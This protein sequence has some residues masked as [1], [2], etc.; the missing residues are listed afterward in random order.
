MQ[1]TRNYRQNV[2]QGLF[3]NKGNLGKD[4]DKQNQKLMETLK[5]E[6]NLHGKGLDL[7]P[8]SQDPLLTQ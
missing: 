7:L 4:A 6:R 5:S 8:K 2:G 1:Q 3:Q